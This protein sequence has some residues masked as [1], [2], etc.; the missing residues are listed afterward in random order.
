MGRYLNPNNNKF[1]NFLKEKY[2]VDKSR[3]F[4]QLFRE[5]GTNK[6]FSVAAVRAVLESPSRRR[7]SWRISAGERIQARFL[8]S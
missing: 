7:C 8:R 4:E 5:D 6:N 2:V 1:R 3:S